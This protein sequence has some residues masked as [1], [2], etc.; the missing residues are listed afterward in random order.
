[1]PQEGFAEP[2]ANDGPG[3]HSNMPVSELTEHVTRA[4][5]ASNGNSTPLVAETMDG[6]TVTKMSRPLTEP[7]PHVGLKEG[8]TC[9]ET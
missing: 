3:F 4:T 9:K 5:E 8:W 7:P 2:I 1:M 6:A